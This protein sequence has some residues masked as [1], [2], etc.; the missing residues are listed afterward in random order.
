M[1]PNTAN[2]AAEIPPFEPIAIIGI[3]IRGP[4]GID[5][6]TTLWDTLVEQKSHCFPLAKD[7]RFHRRFNPED[8]KA[9]FAGIPD[10]ENVLHSNLFDETPG[11]DRS[12]FSL[13]ER[14][15][16]G[17]DVQQKLLL[18][19]AHEALEDAGY[20]GVED[21]SAFDPSTLGVYV[22]TATDEIIQDPRDYDTDIYHLVRTERAFL[23]GQ[24]SFHFGLR[25]PSSTLD[26]VCSGSISAINDACRALATGECRAAIAGGVHVVTPVSGPISFYSIK[27]AGFLDR[28]GQ[29]K[30]FLH[31]GTGYSRSEGCGLVVM[32]RLSDAIREGDRIH[33]VIRGLCIRSMASPKFISQPNGQF[34]SVA[35]AHAVKIS[36][37]DPAAIS[38]V[39]AHGPGTAKGDLAEVSSLCTVLAQHRAT[40]NPV[41]VG[42]LKGNVGH[43]EAASGTHSLAKVIAMFQRRRI[44]PQADFHPSR[45]N[46]TLQP[47]FDKYPIRVIEKEEEWN[48]SHRIAV[49]GNFGAS[50]NAGFM[51]VEEGSSFQPLEGRDT[52]KISSPLPFVISAKDQPTLVKLIDLYIDWLKLPSTSLMSLSDISYAM[53]ARRFVHPFMIS[54]QADSHIDL[55]QKLQERPP[56]IDSS[57]N[58]TPR[59]VAFC[60]SGQGGERVDP[61]DSTLY[62]FSASFTDAVDM[63]FRIAESENL[64]AEE[65]VSTL[66]LFA[67]EFGLMEMWKSWGINPV[68]LAGHSFGEY[69]ALVCAGVLTVR[70]ALKLLG[71]R[72]A[73]IRARCLDIPGKMAAVRIPISEIN[74]CLEQQTSTHVELACINSDNSVT[75]AGTPE[76]LESF[77]QELLKSY[78]AAGW[79]LLGNMTVAFHSQFVEP[80]LADFTTACSEVEIHPSKL[81]VL[82]G[83]LGKTC[84]VGDDALEQP[85]YLPRHCRETNCF[86]TAISDYQRRNV[87]SET[88]QPDWL[89]IG[90]HSRIISFISLASDQLKFPSHGKTAGDGWT[91][92]LS[93]LMKLYSAGHVIDFKGLHRDINPS[94]HHTDL[95]LYPFQFEPHIYPARKEVNGSSAI[96][97]ADQLCPRVPSMELAPLLLN[98]VMAGYTLCP[99]T[100]H[101]ALFLAATATAPSSSQIEGRLGYRLSKIKVIA[102]FTNTTDGW[103]QVRRQL[104]TTDMQIISDDD[105]KIHITGRGEA[106][107]ERDLLESLSL[108]E[109]FILPLKSLKS[110][111]ST[112]VVKKELAYSLFN[113]TVNYGAHGQVLDRVWIAEDGYQA[114]GY[115]TY[116]SG[117][118]TAEGV[119]SA[120]RDF[121]PMLVE[122]VC[123]LI[124]F[125]MN[126]S[127]ER[128]D[129]E[130][131]VTDELGECA[132]A[133]SRL[134][135]TKYVEIYASFKMVDNGTAGLGNVFAFD[136]K[137]QMISAF[138][139][140]RMAKMKIYVLK[141]LIDR[142]RKPGQV[143]ATQQVAPTEVEEDNVENTDF[144]DK[145]VSVLKAALRLSEI[146]RDKSLGE[147]GLD[148]LTAID[149]GV[150]LERLV[151][152]RRDHLTI[153]PEGNLAALLQVLH[154]APLPKSQPITS[155]KESNVPNG[156]LKE[157]VISTPLSQPTPANGV[158]ITANGVPI[159]ANGVPTK[160]NGVPIVPEPSQTLVAN[161]SPEMM[162]A[163]SSNPE[164]IQT[165][166]GRM[167]LLLIHDGGGT[168]FAYYALGNLDRTVIGIHSPGLQDGQGITSVH[169]ATKEYAAIARQYLKQN[170][171]GYSKLLVGGWSL[172]GTISLTMAALFPDLVAGVVTID[173][174]PPGVVGLTADQ[175]ESVLL[176]PWSRTDGIHGLVRRQL[177]M[178]TRAS[179]TYP[180]YQTIV[181]VT[182]VNVPVFALCAIDP[183]RPDE[184]LGLPKETYEWLL[185]FKQ[186]D[187]AEGTW[188]KLVGDRL[189]GIESVPG[190]HWTM[191]T[192]ANVKA[193]TEALRRA[194]DVIEGWLNKRG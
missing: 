98:H 6:L 144:E 114:W 158:S 135:E 63:C 160:T 88:P 145:V 125:L 159:T 61:R 153:D 164:V 66:E 18:H 3:G 81:V 67:L 50:G 71:I 73:L 68:A 75:L 64:I 181:R 33:G 180:E 86:G 40:D 79:H 37:V 152:H 176:Q 59:E 77:R 171:P 78:P 58:R 24:I 53:T 182:A 167:P 13:S 34:Q 8:W 109:S 41:T 132:I 189:V 17:M 173:T 91:T 110:L 148:S 39:E 1:P 16:A 12:Y 14:E 48:A 29:C 143:V 179:F 10:G 49:V 104:P 187:V 186:S 105:N 175:A 7:P 4:G 174:T 151:P 155:T 54:V 126:T 5:S 138:R 62:N 108:D 57:A 194:V 172:G 169:E 137:G 163:I 27:R 149:V 92:A 51:V 44:P 95:P 72:A 117:A 166:P 94:A 115:S 28:T 84:S 42:S 85:D 146:P 31:N 87:E 177:Q 118:R 99:A 131:F 21:G 55:V 141:R 128:K 103:L 80:V 96:P 124:G 97:D 107:K 183:F 35:L 113:H 136:D 119:P 20:S 154:P 22:A 70:D 165:A 90:S 74:K 11:L 82:S 121:S 102:G 112:D 190:N 60:F 76:D 106:C 193:T 178:N 157:K 111:P 127:A 192:P 120:L 19:V 93:T 83:L 45:L 116:P 46:P 191:F 69:V 147:L 38:F 129:G 170:C 162:Q 47:F 130:A 43:A 134:Y 25:G 140:V 65:D 150:Q 122:S 139:D 23:S 26:T 168:A 15:A 188:R 142:G 56:V 30:P 184:S 101:L 156:D 133:I 123:Q 32:K 36:G 9:L 52:V 161:L 185:T 2:K 100:T 89:E